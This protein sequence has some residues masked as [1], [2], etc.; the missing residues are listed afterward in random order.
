MFDKDIQKFTRIKL[1]SEHVFLL[2]FTSQFI[3]KFALAYIHVE[4]VVE[5]DSYYMINEEVKLFS[6]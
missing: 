5:Y 6:D 2:N 1:P 4:F 3:Q